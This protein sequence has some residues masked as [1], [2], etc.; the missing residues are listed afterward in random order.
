M[1]K[2][3][4][5]LVTFPGRLAG[6]QS[7]HSTW[8]IFV[9]ISCRMNHNSPN[10][11]FCLR[12]TKLFLDIIWSIKILLIITIHKTQT[13]STN[14]DV[15]MLWIVK[16]RIDLALKRQNRFHNILINM[17]IR[18]QLIPSGKCIVQQ[19]ALLTLHLLHQLLIFHL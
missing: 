9:W 1:Y 12:T 10:W 6:M 3:I 16:F 19:K 5:H 17:Q 8:M 2:L 18:E 14:N 15:K 13:L 7:K 11:T 4:F